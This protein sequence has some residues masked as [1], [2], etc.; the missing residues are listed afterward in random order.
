MTSATTYDVSPSGDSMGLSETL[1]IVLAE[2]GDAIF[3]ADG[4]YDTAIVSH[5][6]GKEGQPITIQGG[7]DV[8]IKGNYRSRSVLINHSFISLKVSQLT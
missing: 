1:L 2:P 3:L 7:S 4:T 8:V 6:D 5:R